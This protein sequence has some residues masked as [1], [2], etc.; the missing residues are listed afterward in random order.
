[1]YLFL[2]DET[3]RTRS[4][5]SRFFIYGGLIVSGDKVEELDKRIETIRREVPLRATDPLKFDT[6]ARPEGIEISDYTAAKSAVIDACVE[7]GV[8]FVAYMIL[9]DIAKSATG[10]ELLRFAMNTVFYVFDGKFLREHDDIGMCI[11][12]RFDGDHELLRE[13]H[14]RG[15]YMDERDKWVPFD[16]IKLFAA[17]CDGASHLS[18]AVDIVLGAFRYCVNEPEKTE[19]PLQ[20]LPRVAGMMYH[21]RI[22][23]VRHVRDY[24]LITRP[25]EIAHPPY[26]EEYDTTIQR[27]MGLLDQAKA[28]QD[29][30]EAPTPPDGR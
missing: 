24:G 27:L 28:E 3:N 19:V 29:S 13:K 25:A 11:V 22:E 17:T 9:H 5:Q 2:G 20:L 15:F 1:M 30:G 21:R 12:D 26:R 8:Q 10:S 16:R 4:A 14:Q 23:D 18:S 7:T 6:R